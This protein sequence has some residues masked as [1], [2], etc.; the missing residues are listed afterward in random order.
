MP[1]SIE[2]LVLALARARTLLQEH[3]YATVADR[4]EELNVRL[5]R[6]DRYAVVS[7]ISE[8][9]GGAGSLNDISLYA[10]TAEGAEP[11]WLPDANAQLRGLVRDV[12]RTAREAASNLGIDLG[13]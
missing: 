5:E 8:A 3:S 11:I 10:A 1:P 7:A 13:R 12:E 6:G 2:P 4:L 9:T